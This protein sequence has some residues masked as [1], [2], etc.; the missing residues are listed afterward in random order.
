MEDKIIY[1]GCFV[2]CLLF[3]FLN[4]LKGSRILV[5]RQVCGD[6]AGP[7]SSQ[8]VSPQVQ[9]PDQQDPRLGTGMAVAELGTHAAKTQLRA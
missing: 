5:V 9:G 6:E 2:I 7:P 3:H 4:L 8:C 1:Q